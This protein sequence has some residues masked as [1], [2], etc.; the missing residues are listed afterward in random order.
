MTP[1]V[2]VERP[3]REVNS[4]PHY[5]TY[6]PPLMSDQDKSYGALVTTGG[7][8]GTTGG[9]GGTTHPHGSGGTTGGA[10]G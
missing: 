8:G 6:K 9:A 7:A 1:S 5:P 10:G 4:S 3:E 2:P